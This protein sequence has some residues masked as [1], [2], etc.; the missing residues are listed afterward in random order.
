MLEKNV[1]GVLANLLTAN[2]HGGETGRPVLTLRT[3]DLLRG[4]LGK[5]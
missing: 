3:L 2:F 4:V 1:R 5:G